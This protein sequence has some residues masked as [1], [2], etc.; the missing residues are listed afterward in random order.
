MDKRKLFIQLGLIL[1]LVGMY[2]AKDFFAAD[3]QP[4]PVQEAQIQDEPVQTLAKT[5]INDCKE[6]V[7][8]YAKQSAD[9]DRTLPR[10]KFELDMPQTARPDIFDGACLPLTEAADMHY[11][12]GAVFL[13]DGSISDFQDYVAEQRLSDAEYL[14][15]ARFAAIK[16]Y[17]VYEAIQPVTDASVHMTVSGQKKSPEQIL[18]EYV[19]TK[20]FIVMGTN[21]LATSTVDEFI[22]NYIKLI[23]NILQINKQIKII[24]QTIPPVTLYGETKSIYNAKID[25]YNEALAQMAVEKGVSLADAAFRLKDEAGYLAGQLCTDDKSRLNAEAYMIWTEYLLKHTVNG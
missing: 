18:Q 24:V 10:Q 3:M 9:P 5:D 2:V 17:S 15:N 7:F 14:G 4:E 20:V 22:D 1:V 13:G 23:D 16:N 25:V 6:T 21:D 8:H 12:D 11:F 19:A